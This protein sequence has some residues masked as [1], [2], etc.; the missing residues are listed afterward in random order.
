MR[1]A[2]DPETSTKDDVLRV[3]KS[4]DREKHLGL[5]AQ[6]LARRMPPS[7]PTITGRLNQLHEEGRVNRWKVGQAVV[8]WPAREG[9]DYD[10]I[11]DQLDD[12]VEEV[13]EQSGEERGAVVR[14][15]VE[16]GLAADALGLEHPGELERKIE[17]LE[18][19]STRRGEFAVAGGAVTVGFVTVLITLALPSTGVSTL[20]FAETLI[21]A[22]EIVGLLVVLAGLVDWG[23]LLLKPQLSKIGLM[24][25]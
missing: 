25:E 2:D 17:S 13:A 19:K 11:P 3:L 7:R 9:M 5:T 18:E 6:E 21:T 12:D 14:R 22:V 20:P 24:A 23:W 4:R 10:P 1:A 16:V 8:W 15:L